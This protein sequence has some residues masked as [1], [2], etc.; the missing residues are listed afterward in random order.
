MHNLI[1]LGGDSWF[2]YVLQT[3]LD[4]KDPDSAGIIGEAL[5]SYLENVVKQYP[6]YDDTELIIR[7]LEMIGFG[8]SNQGYSEDLVATTAWWFRE[9]KS[10]VL[11]ILMEIKQRVGN[12]IIEPV[13]TWVPEG[14]T[15]YAITCKTQPN[16]Y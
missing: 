13:I 4:E 5:S 12:F 7:A 6:H 2:H 16:Q 8:I 3:E 14:P 1:I 9:I 11:P 10:E 15:I